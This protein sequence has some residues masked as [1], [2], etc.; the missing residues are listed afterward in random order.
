MSRIKNETLLK[1]I[2]EFT[3]ATATL[4]FF[5]FPF[6]FLLRAN[7]HYEVG[8][9]MSRTEKLCFDPGCEK[10]AVKLNMPNLK[11]VQDM[12]F[13]DHADHLIDDEEYLLLYDL[14]QS[15]NLD[16]PHHSHEKFDLGS[17][18][19]VESKSEFR[20]DKRG[21]YTFCDVFEITEEIRRYN[22]MVFD[23]EEALCIFLNR[24]AYPCRYQDLILTLIRAVGGFHCIFYK[25]RN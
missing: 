23:K 2:R 5:T 21:I 3:T 9:K 11:T 24:F 18:N 12:I 7:M 20:S 4:I 10:T 1:E 19:K 22:R 15:K 13:L 8:G 16:L 17:L 6:L 25:R 14:N